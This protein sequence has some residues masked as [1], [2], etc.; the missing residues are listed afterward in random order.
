MFKTTITIPNFTAPSEAV[1]AQIAAE[2]QS[3][4]DANKYTGEE[5]QTFDKETTTKT[6][7]RWNWVDEASATE[8]V[9][10]AVAAIET[11][12]PGVLSQITPV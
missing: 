8:Y 4:L 12:L 10:V 2:V 9:N 7:Q 1:R 5:S 6:V 3:M 11:E